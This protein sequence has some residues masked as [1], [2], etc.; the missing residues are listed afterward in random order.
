MPRAV[1]TMRSRF[2]NDT[3]QRIHHVLMSVQPVHQSTHVFYSS[4]LYHGSA[5]MTR[6]STRNVHSRGQDA[7]SRAPHATEYCGHSPSGRKARLGVLWPKVLGTRALLAV[8][9]RHHSGR[10]PKEDEHHQKSAST[11]VQ[12]QNDWETR[13]SR[14][15]VQM[16]RTMHAVMWHALP[17]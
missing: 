6:G 16:C 12:P 17:S 8:R 4:L 9:C 11:E 10:D 14:K 3:C 2:H 15:T 5:R 13:K 7:T 1:R